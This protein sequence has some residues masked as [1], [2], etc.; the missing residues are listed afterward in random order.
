MKKSINSSTISVI[1]RAAQQLDALLLAGGVRAWR[2][3]AVGRP[4]MRW[5]ETHAGC[6][7]VLD[8]GGP[9]PCVLMTPDGP[10]VIEHYEELLELLSPRLRVVCFDMPGFGFS[11]AVSTYDHSLQSG[12]AA[13]LEVMDQLGIQKATL[14]FSCANGFYAM[15]FAQIAPGRVHALLLSQTPSVIAMHAWAERAVPSILRWPLV[16][17]LIGRMM[18]QKLADAWY[19][20]ALPRT[21]DGTAFRKA[22]RQALR[23]GGCFSLAGVV[24]GLMREPVDATRGLQSGITVLWGM[25]DHSHRHTAPHAMNTDAPLARVVKFEDCGHFP[26]LEDPQRFAKMLFEIVPLAA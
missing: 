12:A 2:R 16:G 18:R 9:G 5:I 3:T 24:Q 26:D 23:C 8:T 14:A 21:T 13:V 11:A 25:K 6:I 15:R 7:R 17:Q 1:Q 22:G 10:N 19:G 20:I 4:G